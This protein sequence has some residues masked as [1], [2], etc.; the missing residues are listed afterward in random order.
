LKIKKNQITNNEKYD[1]I[2]KNINGF[3]TPESLDNFFNLNINSI[4]IKYLTDSR[5][6]KLLNDIKTKKRNSLIDKFKI[7]E[8]KFYNSIIDNIMN[9]NEPNLL[10]EESYNDIYRNI[11]ELEEKYLD[12]DK[13]KIKLHEIRKNRKQ[14]LDTQ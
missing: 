7:E 14:I 12:P 13:T 2:E 5:D 8:N 4:D 10:T 9:C 6:K 3:L 1:L 11:E